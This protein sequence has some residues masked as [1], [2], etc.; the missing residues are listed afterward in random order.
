[1]Y[2]YWFS[3]DSGYRR[4]RRRDADNAGRHSTTIR[5]TYPQYVLRCHTSRLILKLQ[6]FHLLVV[7]YDLLYTTIVGLQ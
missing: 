4:Q 7:V 3:S 5:E 1:M 6:C 2:I